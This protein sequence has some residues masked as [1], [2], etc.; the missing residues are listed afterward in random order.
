[1]DGA[2]IRLVQQHLDGFAL[3]LLSEATVPIEAAFLPFSLILAVSLHQ[4]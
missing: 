1:M 2:G 3:E 4:P